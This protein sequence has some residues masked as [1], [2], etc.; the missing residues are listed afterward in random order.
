ELRA[1]L[2]SMLALAILLGLGA[3]AVMTMA[4]GARRTD[5][6]YGR[7]T[8][9]HKA[10][11]M[12]VFPSFGTQFASLDFTKVAAGP[13]V[14]ASARQHFLGTTEQ[15]V[16]VI[17]GDEALGTTINRLKVLEGRMPRSD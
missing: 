6:A 8:R 14:I 9:T 5:S 11:D 7:F 15:D 3:G 10:A 4:A 12:I 2:P 1:R 17:A 13:L 16:S